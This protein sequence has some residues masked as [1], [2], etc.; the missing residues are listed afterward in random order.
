M[1][2]TAMPPPLGTIPPPPPPPQAMMA[3]PPV[4][5]PAPPRPHE[6]DEHVP[7]PFWR[8]V[9]W[10]FHQALKM[11]FLALAWAGRDRRR[12]VIVGA[13]IVGLILGAVALGQRGAAAN[14]PL[15]T[16]PGVGNPTASSFSIPY[17]TKDLPPLPASVYS[18]M[19]ALHDFDA[20]SFWNT[21]DATAQQT[22]QKNGETEQTFAQAFAKAK[23]DGI[24]YPQFY[25]TGGFASPDGTWNYTVQVVIAQGQSAQVDTWY[26]QVISGGQILHFANIS[27]LINS[28]TQSH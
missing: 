22:L 23:S 10:P 26:F 8:A 19:K 28:A 2:Q 6:P 1:S 15:A 3:T 24:T 12:A 5:P 21:L 27:A 7:S 11:T 17:Y 4:P 14:A 18:M 25:Y 16:A 9:R 13:I 20:Q